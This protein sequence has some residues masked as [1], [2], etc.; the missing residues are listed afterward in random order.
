MRYELLIEAENDELLILNEPT[1]YMELI[2]DIDSKKCLETMKYEIDS[3]YTN[4][5]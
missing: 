2:S 4:K 1:N 5:V 3:M